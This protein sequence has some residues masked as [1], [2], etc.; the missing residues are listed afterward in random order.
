MYKTYIHEPKSENKDGLIELKSIIDRNQEKME[1]ETV[2]DLEKAFYMIDEDIQEIE[3]SQSILEEIETDIDKL[4]NK[5][6]LLAAKNEGNK[7]IEESFNL[8][9]QIYK[10]VNSY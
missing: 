2:Y 4:F 9:Q 5:L 1:C 10:K 6:D 7:E 3:A 8:I